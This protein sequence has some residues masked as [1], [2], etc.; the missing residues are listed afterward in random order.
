MCIRDSPDRVVVGAAVAAAVRVLALTASVAVNQSRELW[1]EIVACAHVPA[2]A[3]VREE[4][5]FSAEHRRHGL[6]AYDRA[7]LRDLGV[8]AAM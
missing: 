6:A 1:A 4:T 2:H 7:V 5:G 3:R 8:A